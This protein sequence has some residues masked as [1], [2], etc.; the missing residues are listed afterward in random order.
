VAEGGGCSA[1]Q[2]ELGIGQSTINTPMLKLETRL[3]YR[4]C[5]FGKVGFNLPP[6]RG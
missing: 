3:G 6:K 2:G 1:A 4:L 5:E